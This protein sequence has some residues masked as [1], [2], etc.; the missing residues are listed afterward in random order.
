MDNENDKF[1]QISV[2]GL[3]F[4]AEGKLMMMQE[5]NGLW[6]LPGGRVQKGEDLV[7]CVRRECVEETGIDCQVLEQ[8]P[9]IVYSTIDKEGRPRLMV[10]FKIHLDNL[11]FKASDEC[12]AMKFFTKEEIRGLETFPQI[13]PLADYL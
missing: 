7:E 4:N 8:Q 11:D 13:K 5:P 10:Y 9:S 1:F 6:E 12:V 2:K 3:F